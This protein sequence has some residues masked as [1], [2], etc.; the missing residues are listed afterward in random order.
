MPG[1]GGPGG[2]HPECGTSQPRELGSG[3]GAV[4]G[5]VVALQRPW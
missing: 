2:P 4:E 1:P 5:T 3:A